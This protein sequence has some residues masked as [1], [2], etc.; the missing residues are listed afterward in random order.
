MYPL[1]WVI[2]AGGL[3]GSGL[4]RHLQAV[5][6]IVVRGPRVRWGTPDAVTDLAAGLSHLVATSDGR[7]WQVYWCAGVGVTGSN[8]EAFRAEVSTFEAFLESA[9]GLSANSLERGSFF[10]ASSAG[11]VYGGSHGAPFHELSETAPLGDYGWAKIAI[12][13]ATA[14][15][16]KSTGVRCLVGRIS[17]LYGPG[18]SL[19]KPQGLISHLSLSSLTR[20]PLSVFVS[21]D[22]LRDYLYVDDGAELIVAGCRRLRQ[23]TGAPFHIK[24]IAAGRSV[25]IGAL[26]SE[27]RRVSGRRPEIV[28]GSSPQSALQNI[29]LRLQSRYW[30]ELD[31]RAK[32]NL[33]DGIARTLQDIRSSFLRAAPSRTFR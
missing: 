3:L 7:D 22:T 10:V 21:L 19:A 32:T 2:G 18:Q 30:P 33:T 16:S 23:S 24:I 28:M 14:A 29:D 25:S 31:H 9:R 11:G 8:A 26:L 17:N 5:G 6:E 4:V 27:F 13:N 20:K 1:S 15:F 12:E